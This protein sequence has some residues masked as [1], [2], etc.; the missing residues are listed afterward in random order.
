MSDLLV[1]VR[2]V[3]DI[4]SAVAHRLFREGYAVVTHDDPQPTTSRRG[5][6]FTDAVFDGHAVLEHVRALRADNLEE[7]K[8]ALAAHDTIPVCIG[9]LESLLIGLK[10]RILIDAQIRKHAPPESQRGLAPLTIGL[11][12]GFVAGH[13]ADVVIETSWDDLGRV[14]T[15]GASLPLSGE[16]RTIQG[17]ARDRYVYAPIAGLFRTKAQI[18]DAVRKGEPVAQIDSL[19]LAAPLDGVLRGLTHD[20]VPV[21][22][23]TKVIEVDPRGRI[24]EVRGIAE[25]PRRIAEGVLSAVRDWERGTATRSS[26]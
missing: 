8:R 2:S 12:P 16:P 9:P 1:L 11:G 5:M 21:A 17:H 20:S 23:R 14:I 22:L 13:H 6:A 3:G 26:S 19:A 24:S 25:R 10:P 18:G 7:T 15:H 4:G